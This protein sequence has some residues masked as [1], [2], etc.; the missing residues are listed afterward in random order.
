MADHA[1][2]ALQLDDQSRRTLAGACRALI[3]SLTSVHATAL[4]LDNVDGFGEL[5]SARE[6]S[7]KFAQLGGSEGIQLSL[8]QHIAVVERIE[9][10]LGKSFDQY[11]E[12]DFAL[13]EQ[14]SAIGRQR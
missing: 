1:G 7:A 11:D 5:P 10:T 6:L 14:L 12:A 2:T 13:L 8:R 4:R 9:Q 3:E